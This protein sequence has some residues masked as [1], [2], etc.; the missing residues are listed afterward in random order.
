MCILVT[1]YIITCELR[2]N[3]YLEIENGNYSGKS[4]KTELQP[5]FFQ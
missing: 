2:P 1:S 4:N 3:N 5:L